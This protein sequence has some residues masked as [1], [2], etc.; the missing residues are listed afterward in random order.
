[1]SIFTLVRFCCTH[2]TMGAIISPIKSGKKGYFF[3]LF[4]SL[5]RMFDEILLKKCWNSF[6][7]KMLKFKQSFPK[8]GFFAA[9]KF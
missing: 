5:H 3:D 1:M 9:Q 2:C 7:Y 8:I 6:D 4:F